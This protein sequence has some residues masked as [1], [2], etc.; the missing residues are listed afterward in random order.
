MRHI[1]AAE[2]VPAQVQQV[3]PMWQVFFGHDQPVTRYREARR[4][5]MLFFQHF[6]AECQARGVYFHN[7]Y[8]ERWFAST[9]AHAGGEEDLS[10]EAIEAAT[11]TAKERLA[12]LPT[13]PAGY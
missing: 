13:L 10:L 6:Q 3:G 5:D 2:G 7:Y 9:A 11:K 1:F 12:G 4:S 8:L